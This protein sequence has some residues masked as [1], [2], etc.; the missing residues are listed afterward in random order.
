MKYLMIGIIICCSLL[1]ACTNKEQNKPI[2]AKDS[3]YEEDKNLK[4]SENDE[5]DKQIKEEKPSIDYNVV[6]PNEIGHIMI[7]MYHG[8]QNNPPYHRTV[9]NF[10]KDLEYMYKHNFRLI[11]MNDYINNNINIPAGMTPIVLTFDDGLSTTFSLEQKNGEFQPIKN[12]AVAILEEFAKQHP[13]FGK[14]AIFYINGDLKIFEGAGT[15]KERLKWLVDNGYEVANH[16]STHAKLSKLDSSGVQKE[17]GKTDKL[18]K[19]ALGSDYKIESLSYPFGLRPKEELLKYALKGTYEN[20]TYNYKIALKEGPSK[21]FYPPTHIS[22]DPLLVPRVRG[23]EGDIQD[24]H[25]FFEHYEKNK[26][27][28]YI[29]DGMVEQ[30]SV[31]KEL[32]DKI[33]KD[34]LK[35][36]NIY[37][38]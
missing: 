32:E 33:N 4:T 37:L 17:I 34:V 26:K 8:I 14:K 1:S 20:N 30:I 23:S 12:T 3:T 29:S 22:F 28:L 31:P 25:W 27:E 24:L 10:K 19:E 35:D 16:T 15:V 36:K 5:K 38:Y 6:K 2:P 13:D 18:I 11:S 21:L 9:E 7:V